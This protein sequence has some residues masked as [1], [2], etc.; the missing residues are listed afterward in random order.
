MRK[1]V[2]AEASALLLVLGTGEASAFG[3]TGNIR[4]EE[5][6]YAILAPQTVTPTAS[7]PPAAEQPPQRAVHRAVRARARSAKPASRAY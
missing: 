7:A 2:L 6:P 1:L 3:G 4:P 5:S